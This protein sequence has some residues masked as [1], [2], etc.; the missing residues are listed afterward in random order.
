M[1]DL[2]PKIRGKLPSLL[3]YL[4]FETTKFR[5][6]LS[7]AKEDT[8]SRKKTP[9]PFLVVTESDPVS[10]L[11]EARI[12][13]DAGSELERVFV[14]MQKDEYL[15][16]RD[17]LCPINNQDIC[18][19]WQRAF[20]FYKG[21]SQDRNLVVLS[22]QIGEGGELLPFQSLFFCRLKRIF[23]HPP[24]PGCGLPLQQCC[25]NELLSGLGLQPYSTSLKRYLFCPSCFALHGTSDFYVFRLEESD[26]PILKDGWDLIRGFGL[27]A[28]A[29]KDLNE[30]PCTECPNHKECYGP[31]GLVVSRVAPFS[32]YPFFMLV[33]GAMSVS[34]LD[35]LPLISGASFD[36]IET[37]L[38]KKGEFGRINC[39]KFLKGDSR[40]KVPFLFAV[41]DRHFLE[42]LYLK[43]S[44]LAGVTQTTLFEF[45]ACR[46][47]H[48]RLSMENL[49][50]KL[51][52][53][54]GLL[55]FFWNFKVRLI[56]IG[57]N[58]SGAT[59]LPQLPPSYGLHFLGL[60]W[61]YVLLVNAEQNV[62]KVYRSLAQALN[63]VS[64]GDEAGHK[65]SLNEESD[66][67]FFPENIFWNPTAKTVHRD[68]HCIWERSLDLGWLLLRVSLNGNRDWSKEKF[69][70]G[71]EELREEVKMVLFKE[72]PG[73]D[74]EVK[75][76]QD[77]AIR[78]ILLNIM[79]KWEPGPEVKEEPLEETVVISAKKKEE[80][81]KTV[82]I[83]PSG[84]SKDSRKACEPVRS[85]SVISTARVGLSQKEPKE[86]EI[87]SKTEDR[88][89]E[90]LLLA[91]TVIIKP[92]KAPD[93]DIDKE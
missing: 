74:Q 87:S 93:K 10:R 51:A 68:W 83:S 36:E 33:L 67:T 34:A 64:P 44:F 84:I 66:W 25:D 6:G 70:Q 1:N 18:E 89:E 19:Y 37:R 12:M 23:F 63:K 73:A 76:S 26:P 4:G 27:L 72:K 61:F 52:D 69:W 65:D 91:E 45:E 15:L 50:V 13:T 54:S 57:R 20:S 40:V 77:E 8:S 81:D 56:D 35:F 9:F 29:G 2:D 28:G 71:L 32:F 58:A 22:D 80:L 31:D 39:L 55:P 59:S 85:K 78:G 30:F 41:D 17:E 14:L 53:Q 46:D 5:L 79:K 62:S 42:V 21:T 24:C 92:D 49:W 75:R 16:T 90:D 43:L 11:I 47:A 38:R 60:V 48:L 86:S 7:L 3:P 88:P 82:V